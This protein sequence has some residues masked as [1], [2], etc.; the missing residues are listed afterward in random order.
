MKR[1]LVLVAVCM[2]VAVP[3]QAHETPEFGRAG[4][5]ELGVGGTIA[6]WNGAE[7]GKPDVASTLITMTATPGIFLWDDVQLFARG[8]VNWS[9]DQAE[10]ADPLTLHYTNLGGGLRYHFTPTGWS[11]FPYVEASGEFLT[12]VA[13]AGTVD[14]NLTGR[15]FDAG[16][17]LAWRLGHSGLG[18]VGA[19]FFDEALDVELPTSSHGT[20]RSGLQIVLSLAFLVEP[21]SA[22]GQ[23]A[24]P[25]PLVQLTD[26]EIVIADKIYFEFGQ[27]TLQPISYP[28]LD[29]VAALLLDN[30]GVQLVEVAGHTDDVGKAED[31][32]K[33]SQARSEAVAIYLGGKGVPYS[34]MR[35]RGYGESQPRQDVTG[36]EK[37]PALKAKLEEARG[38][39]RRV[40]FRILTAPTP[41]AP[42]AGAAE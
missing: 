17:G 28:L 22:R 11:A 25:K 3:A 20:G 7:D 40:E 32:L 5:L 34:R 21:E 33:L 36:W 41:A 31:N 42:P 23:A 29:E 19:S 27:A 30:P 12:G 4:T 10:N 1:S 39:N 18:R 8:G 15:R 35:P 14:A 26:T 13:D 24:A 38:H 9:R 16:V 2:A 6:R 37:D